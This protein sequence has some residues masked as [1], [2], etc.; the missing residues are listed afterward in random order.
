MNVQ[1]K[2]IESNANIKQVWYGVL[3]SSGYLSYTSK[4]EQDASEMANYEYGDE[5]VTLVQIV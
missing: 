5:I 3:T 4:S 1:V 2:S